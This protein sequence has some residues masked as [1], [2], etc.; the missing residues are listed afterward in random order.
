MG[1]LQIWGI[2]CSSVPLPGYLTGMMVSYI[3]VFQQQNVPI[4]SIEVSICPKT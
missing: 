2:L 4:L 3:G 1:V